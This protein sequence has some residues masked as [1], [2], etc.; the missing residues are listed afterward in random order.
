MYQMTATLIDLTRQQMVG[1]HTLTV[2]SLSGAERAQ[3]C[4]LQMTQQMMD[5]QLDA[6]GRATAS[7]AQA[8]GAMLDVAQLQ[9]AM[10]GLLRS[11]RDLA[12]A[13]TDTQR[14][15]LDVVTASGQ[16]QAEQ[17]PLARLGEAWQ[18][19]MQ[20]WQQWTEQ[21]LAV[22]RT[23]AEQWSQQVAQQGTQAAQATADIASA[24]GAQAAQAA[25]ATEAVAQ[26]MQTTP[27]A[28]TDQP[29]NPPA[30]L[31]RAGVSADAQ[32]DE[33]SRRL[34]ASAQSAR[35]DGGREGAR[36]GKRVVEAA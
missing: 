33:V 34:E 4:A 18:Q 24:T 22:T 1:M 25:H 32:A 21:W 5:R 23:Q 11:Q 31:L 12:Q 27:S 35:R 8:A 17:A 3:Q 9:P 16:Q 13:M 36:D 20:Q 26:T 14:R 6:V 19:A 10:D 28:P 7:T 30:A 29:L 2:A 15:C